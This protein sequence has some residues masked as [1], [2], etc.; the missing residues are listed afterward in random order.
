MT[1]ASQPADSTRPIDRRSLFRRAGEIGLIA[2][3]GPVLAGC[4]VLAARDDDRY[5]VTITEGRRFEP[6]SL[7]VPAGSTVV[8]ENASTRP[9]AVSTD[10]ARFEGDV[11]IVLPDGVEPF[12]SIDLVTGQTWIRNLTVPGTY[13]YACPY[14]A[15][16]GM[17]GMIVVEQ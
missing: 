9:H 3:A 15:G 10:A 16:E 17:L 13:V 8:W 1:H 2:V 11:W 7:T 6:A 5:T 12:T 14:H 4:D